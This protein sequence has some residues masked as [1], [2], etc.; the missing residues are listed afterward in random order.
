MEGT[1]T[2][3]ELLMFNAYVQQYSYDSEIEGILWLSG[4]GSLES[5]FIG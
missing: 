1:F 2:V 3:L 4:V 5:L